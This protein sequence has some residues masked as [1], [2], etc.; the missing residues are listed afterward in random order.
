M[1]GG[2]V[3]IEILR[4]NDR[5]N[6]EVYIDGNRVDELTEAKIIETIGTEYLDYKIQ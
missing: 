5:I 3:K 4:S 1:K 6:F 2:K